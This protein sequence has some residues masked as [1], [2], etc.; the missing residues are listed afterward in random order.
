MNR[1]LKF[2][3]WI[4]YLDIPNMEYFNLDNRVKQYVGSDCIVMQFI[5]IKDRQNVDVYE[6]DVIEYSYG[7]NNV[8][9]SKVIFAD[10][11]EK[12]DLDNDSRFVGFMCQFRDGDITDFPIEVDFKVIG[13]IHQDPEL[14]K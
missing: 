6:D 7:N 9:R 12:G 8:F 11:I 4:D 13:N 10:H 14:F 5:G 1:E 2:R 3:A